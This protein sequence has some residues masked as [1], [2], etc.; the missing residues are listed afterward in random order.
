MVPEFLEFRRLLI[1]LAFAALSLVATGAGAEIT[2]RWARYPAISPDARTLVFT[3]RGDLWRVAAGGGTAV[4]L[5]NSEAHDY[6]PVWSPDGRYL[7]FASNRH[8]NFDVYV[9]PA[10]G[11][12]ARRLTTHSA[13]EQPY[14]FTADS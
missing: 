2:P 13:D 6:Q 9:M 7:A 8:G 12:V 5:T 3:Y 10:A 11:G 1:A 14:T 4:L